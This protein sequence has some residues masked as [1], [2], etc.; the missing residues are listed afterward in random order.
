MV[1]DESLQLLYDNLKK[2]DTGIILKGHFTGGFQINIS[3]DIILLNDN[4]FLRI[5][6]FE[7]STDVYRTLKYS[8]YP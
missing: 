8:C 4:V 7:D 5:E 1:A 2:F 6:N 3:L